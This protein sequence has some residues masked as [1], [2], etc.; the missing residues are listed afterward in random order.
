M[1]ANSHRT[2]QS[3]SRAAL[4]EDYRAR[5]EAS[6]LPIEIAVAIADMVDLALRSDRD[7]ILEEAAMCA[8]SVPTVLCHNGDM[9]SERVAKAIRA[10]KEAAQ[11]VP[12]AAR[13]GASDA[14]TDVFSPVGAAPCVMVP[15][16]L[17]ERTEATF[18][19][20]D[21]DGWIAQEWLD[22]LTRPQSERKLP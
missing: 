20:V 22:V 14:P 16:S 12:Q 19:S 11:Q 17:A 4:P 8:E 10:L 1:V 6:N 2:P 7:A 9:F 3:R 15:R 18:R 21:P 5:L 13:P